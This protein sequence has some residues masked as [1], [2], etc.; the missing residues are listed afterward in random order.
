MFDI[1]S[2]SAAEALQQLAVARKQVAAAERRLLAADAADVAGLSGEQL[3]D[4]LDDLEVDARRRTAVEAGWS[5]NWTPVVWPRSGDTPRPRC[6]WPS[7]CGLGG[8]TRPAGSGWP[9]S[10]GRGGR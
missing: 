9:P 6:C 4:L 1:G 3:L 2:S 8:E 10:W 5:P 7:G